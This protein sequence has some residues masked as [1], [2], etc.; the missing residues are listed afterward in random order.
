L[1]TLILVAVAGL[2][3][4]IVFR[5]FKTIL[6]WLLIIF[7]VVLAVAYFSN[8]DQSHHWQGIRDKAKEMVKVEDDALQI[9]DYKVVSIARIRKGGK[10]KI[11]GVGAFGKVWYFEDVL[12]EFN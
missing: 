6:K 1:E 3:L 9:S 5:I 2:A 7:V 12:K 10:E 4:Y 11:V 8:P